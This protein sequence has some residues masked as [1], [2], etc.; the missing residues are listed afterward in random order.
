MLVGAGVAVVGAG[1]WY[2]RLCA[3]K[4]K[5]GALFEA[6]LQGDEARVAELPTAASAP[7]I[8]EVYLKFAWPLGH[9]GPSNTALHILH[10]RVLAA[11]M[12]PIGVSAPPSVS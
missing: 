5:A 10:H 8:L 1:L 3:A 4:A 11:S 12:R 7:G 2:A 6:A 9:V